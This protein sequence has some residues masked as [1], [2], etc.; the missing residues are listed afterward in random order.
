MGGHRQA[1][2]RPRRARDT[3]LPIR[4]RIARVAGAGTQ[5][6]ATWKPNEGE[7]L[8]YVPDRA[9][10][11]LWPRG[12]VLERWLRERPSRCSG[13]ADHLLGD[14]ERAE[15]AELLPPEE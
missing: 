15:L 6:A 1:R 8:A 7:S 4:L 10:R 12:R 3:A 5:A 14:L 13:Q 11:P 2:R 9:R